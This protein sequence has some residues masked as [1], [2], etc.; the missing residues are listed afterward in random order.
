MEKRLPSLIFAITLAQILAFSVHAQTPSIIENIRFPLWAEL[1]AYPELAG[2]QDVNDDV[3][4]FPIR[5]IKQ[6]APF[7]IGGMVYGWNF[8]Y[9]P[10]DKQRG[11]EEYFEFTEVMPLGNAEK[12]INYSSP[13]IEDG[14]LNVWVNF[15]RDEQMA[16]NYSLWSSINN[17]HIRGRGYG[18]VSD[19]FDG[20][21]TAARNALKESIREYFR[22]RIKNKPKRIDG[23]VLIICEPELGITSGQYVVQLDFFLETSRIVT[24]TQY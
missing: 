10:S 17:P 21:T 7:F 23:S 5:Q 19:G 18:R 2:K 16:R 8:S 4:D 3:F 6:V 14:L 20:I 9:T 24:Y 13:W 12:R 11:V 1:D 22:G 15:S